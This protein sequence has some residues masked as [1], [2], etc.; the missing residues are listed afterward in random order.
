MSMDAKETLYYALGELAYSVAMADGE[1]QLEEGKKVHDLLVEEA[2]K[3]NFEYDITEIIFKILEKQKLDM[4]T[5]LA[6]AKKEMELGSH[7]L[8]DDLKK[9]FIAFVEGV[10]KAYP[11]YTEKER[12]VVEEFRDFLNAL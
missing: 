2:Q 5:T 11:P 10:A 4:A 3:R 12:A 9:E 8:T 1:V 6:W 7:K